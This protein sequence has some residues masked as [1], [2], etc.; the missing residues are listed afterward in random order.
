MPFDIVYRVQHWNRVDVCPSSVTEK[1]CALFVICSFFASQFPVFSFF[2]SFRF[3]L[4]LNFGWPKFSCQPHSHRLNEPISRYLGWKSK[5]SRCKIYAYTHAHRTNQRRKRREEERKTKAS[6][7][8]FAFGCNIVWHDPCFI[9]IHQTVW[10][11]SFAAVWQR[12]GFVRRCHLILAV[13]TID[14]W[15][16]ATKHAYGG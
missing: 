10:E 14:R 8:L 16:T 6:N 3:S 15:H 7:V 12:N 5:I 13:P 4:S 1:A 11:F 2:F 9:I